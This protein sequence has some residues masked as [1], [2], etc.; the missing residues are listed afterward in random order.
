[1]DNILVYSTNSQKYTRVQYILNRTSNNARRVKL[2]R[3]PY[4][5]LKRHSELSVFMKIANNNVYLADM[6]I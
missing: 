1:M 3:F 2:I 6:N 4:I 5:F